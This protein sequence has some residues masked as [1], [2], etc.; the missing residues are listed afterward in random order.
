MESGGWKAELVHVPLHCQE[1]LSAIACCLLCGSSSP[2][3]VGH[4]S[5]GAPILTF[6]SSLGVQLCSNPHAQGG[7]ALGW[8]SF[9]N[10]LLHGKLGKGSNKCLQEH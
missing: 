6:R 1:T 7:F 2:H 5:N 8:A 9:V 4:N 3:H 10:P